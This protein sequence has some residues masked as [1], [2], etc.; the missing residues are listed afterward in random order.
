MDMKKPEI[1][2]QIQPGIATSV[3]GCRLYQR[4][5]QPKVSS[6]FKRNF[7]GKVN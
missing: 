7:K 2:F 5:V 4:Q 3:T 1:G 6:Q